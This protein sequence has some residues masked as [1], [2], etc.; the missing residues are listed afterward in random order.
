MQL[1]NQ[2]I[3]WGKPFPIP[4]KP[5]TLGQFNTDSGQHR[6]ANEVYFHPPEHSWSQCFQQ[7]LKLIINYERL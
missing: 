5:E 3:A 1:W 2:T 6:L 7:Q 4:A